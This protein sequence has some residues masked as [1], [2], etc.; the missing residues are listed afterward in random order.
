MYLSEIAKCIC[1]PCMWVYWK[2]KREG[3]SPPFWP[4]I[5]QI[6]VWTPQKS[7]KKSYIRQYFHR[8]DNEIQFWVLLC[9]FFFLTYY[10]MV[11]MNWTLNMLQNFHKLISPSL[12]SKSS[13]EENLWRFLFP[14][15]SFVLSSSS[16]HSYLTFFSLTFFSKC[17]SF[18]S[19]TD[20]DW[21]R[22]TE[23]DRDWTRLTKTDQTD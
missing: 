19:E 13:M 11:N 18:F 16:L 22:L 14:I 15:L 10:G 6:L 23:T 21:P 2:G 4:V 5:K 9:V 17:F 12:E 8:Y 20:Q 7:K 1:L 3:S